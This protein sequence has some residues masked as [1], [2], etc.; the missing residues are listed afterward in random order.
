MCFVIYVSLIGLL[1]IYSDAMMEQYALSERVQDTDWIVVAVGWEILPL[2]WSLLLIGMLASSWLTIFVLR[3]W[4]K[5][6]KASA[7]D[8]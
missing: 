7:K 4:D 6:G 1:L 8:I 3:Q 5:R 2:V